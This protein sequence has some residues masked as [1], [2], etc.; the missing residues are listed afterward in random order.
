M[1]SPQGPSD[2]PPFPLLIAGGST[3]AAAFSALR[4]GFRPYCFDHYGDAD[5]HA[6]AEAHVVADYPQG[7]I[8]ALETHPEL[9]LMYAG[10]LE[11]AGNVLDFL[12][13]GRPFLGNPR[14]VVRNV[15]DPELVAETFREFSLPLLEV[16]SMHD[17]PPR[18][19]EWVVKP[20]AGAGGRGIAVWDADA[21]IPDEPHY[22]QQRARGPSYSAVFIAPADQ[23]DV[24]FVGITRQL[25]G[26]VRLGASPF[27]W[28]G[29]LGPETLNVE[30]EQL[31]RRIGNILSWR[32]GL[33]GLFGLDFI[34][35]AGGVPRLTEVNP[36]YTGSVEVLEHTLR[37]ALVRDHCAVFGAE[38]PQ[39]VSVSP[40][41]S[42]LGKFIL[43][44]TKDWRAPDPADWLLPDEW[45][46]ADMWQHVPRVADI[47]MAGTL[48]HAGQPICS[49]FVPAESPSECLEKLP[50]YLGSVRSRLG[51]P[52]IRGM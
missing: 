14:D 1:T 13:M 30:I 45:M 33:A 36:R 2:T 20:L 27:A 24:R 40:G 47:P 44:A 22:F 6:V 5:L 9:P 16:H 4:A 43:Y 26:D 19:G 42:A 3:R 52:A 34:V 21:P 46:H 35:D 10:A 7:L 17:A 31:V 23:R 11:N 32:L 29:S 41:V 38:V 12:E 48:L 50:E 37:L 8:G 15:R 39:Q 18:D 49:L 51:L 25:I 28:C